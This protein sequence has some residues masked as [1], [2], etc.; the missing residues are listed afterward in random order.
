MLKPLE[1]YGKF[2]G[3]TGSRGVKVKDARSFVDFVCRELPADVEV[4]LF[5][6]D[7]VASWQHLYFAALNAL[8]PGSRT[9][10]R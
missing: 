1:E 7:L 5:E 3:I 10:M 6:A 2:V 4:Q 8:S 9:R